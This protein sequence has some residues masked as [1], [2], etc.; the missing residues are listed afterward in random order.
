[1]PITRMNRRCGSRI[2]PGRRRARKDLR[3]RFVSW[4]AL[5]VALATS[6]AFAQSTT[7]S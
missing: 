7:T 4:L 2:Q 1:M 5:V 6:S 3:M